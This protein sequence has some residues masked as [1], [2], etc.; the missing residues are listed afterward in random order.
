MRGKQGREIVGDR[1]GRWG[2]RG[3]C[4]CEEINMN[5]GKPVQSAR[6]G[7]G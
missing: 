2:R 1:N 5:A 6:V 3:K 4:A 7:K